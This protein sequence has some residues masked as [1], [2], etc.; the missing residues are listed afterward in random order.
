MLEVLHTDRSKE[1]SP[2]QNI[3]HALEV[4][5]TSLDDYLHLIIPAV[6][7]LLEQVNLICPHVRVFA[8]QTLGRLC[9]KLNFS[10]YASRIIH[11]LARI[12]DG[13][14]LE[15]KNV[16]MVPSSG[17]LRTAGWWAGTPTTAACGCQISDICLLPPGNPLHTRVSARLR[18]RHL[19]PYGKQSAGQASHPALRL[20]NLG[21]QVTPCRPSNSVGF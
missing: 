7:K 11:P 2:T 17:F 19:H 15:L 8:I 12:L 6:V 5:G 20:R 3:L 1:R 4:L 16:A 9:K 13:D 10:D 21:L 14:D 18:L